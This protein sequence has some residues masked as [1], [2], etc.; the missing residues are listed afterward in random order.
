MGGGPSP[1]PAGIVRGE[2]PRAPETN[3]VQ[4]HVSNQTTPRENPSQ[5]SAASPW[6][7]LS[8]QYTPMDPVSVKTPTLEKSFVTAVTFTLPPPQPAKSSQ[9]T[10]EEMP[11]RSPWVTESQRRGNVFPRPILLVSNPK[12]SLRCLESYHPQHPFPNFLSTTPS[13]VHSKC[14]TPSY[15]QHPA[16]T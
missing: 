4:S 9:D 10:S 15:V 6:S 1:S 2:L 7:G 5:L 13:P 12:L 16:C 3:Q 14:A 8:S 11:L